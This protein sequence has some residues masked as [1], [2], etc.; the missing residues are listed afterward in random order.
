MI[1]F[2]SEKSLP[3]NYT[4]EILKENFTKYVQIC[5]LKTISRR[6]IV[7]IFENIR[8]FLKFRKISR[9]SWL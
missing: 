2:H 5:E 8:K 7:N 3:K 6:K 4:I 1:Y 9:K